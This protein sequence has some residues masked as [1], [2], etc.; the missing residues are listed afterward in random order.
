VDA[1]KAVAKAFTGAQVAVPAAQSGSDVESLA[2]IQFVP[3]PESLRK[4]FCAT[5]YPQKTSLE[6]DKRVLIATQRELRGLYDKHISDMVEILKEVMSLRRETNEKGED[7]IYFVLNEKFSTAPEGGLVVLEQIIGKARTL[8]ANHFLAVEK[9]YT[10]A[11]LQL[12]RFRRGVTAVNNPE[13]ARN[14]LE[15]ANARLEEDA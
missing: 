3:I 14:L 15:K 13:V 1:V 5:A 7:R 4:T 2:N 12:A 9:K 6:D 11:L 10:G 8:I